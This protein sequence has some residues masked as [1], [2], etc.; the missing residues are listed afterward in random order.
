MTRHQVI[1]VVVSLVAAV[2]LYLLPRSVVDND[3]TIQEEE[4]SD[5]SGSDIESSELKPIS[6]LSIKDSIEVEKFTR[7]IPSELSEN[8]ANF[9]DSLAK[10]YIRNRL[11]SN[12]EQ[13]LN[14]LKEV[15]DLK[16]GILYHEMMSIST[17]SGQ[18]SRY[19][20]RARTILTKYDDDLDIKAKLAMTYMVTSNPMQGVGIL[21][22]IIAQD[23]NHVDALYNLG[24]LSI[25]S[26]QYDKA[27]KRFEKVLE[28]SPDHPT[29][30]VYLGIGYYESKRFEEAK[31][32]FIKLS[33][34]EDK[35]ILSIVDDYLQ[36]LN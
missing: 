13:V 14:R 16:A 1:A 4:L 22:E 20:E 8:S 34:S 24:M 7:L 18:I 6:S 17:E 3:K 2:G 15:D 12:A 36:K 29:A 10:I 9:A 19:A 23:S 28:V 21:R 31:R 25:Q 30:S 11:F 5:N 27:V 26:G 32:V 35:E 33:K